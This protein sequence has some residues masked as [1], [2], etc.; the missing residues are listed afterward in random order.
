MAASHAERTASGRCA[1]AGIATATTCRAS[2]PE[3]MLGAA[4][5]PFKSP[6]VLLPCARR[7]V[8]PSAQLPPPASCS[9]GCAP[10]CHASCELPLAPSVRQ[11]VALAPSQQRRRGRQSR[12]PAPPARSTISAASRGQNACRPAGGKRVRPE[13]TAARQPQR[14]C[15]SAQSAVGVRVRW[16]SSSA[17]PGRLR[18]RCDARRW[19]RSASCSVLS[20]RGR[21]QWPPRR[22]KRRT[23]RGA[24]KRRPKPSSYER[25]RLRLSALPPRRRRRRGKR[26]TRRLHA[27]RRRRRSKQ[28]GSA[29]RRKRL[30]PS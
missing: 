15:F 26:R 2:R 6:R 27:R 5:H 13:H 22:G 3:H 18:W 10:I 30:P 14:Q 11:H 17:R 1:L 16:P 8:R 23:R 24:R 4:S 12:P 21:R 7:S 20:A 28:R 9:A 25:S 19:R 29:R